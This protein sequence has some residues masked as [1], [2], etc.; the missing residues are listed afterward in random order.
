MLSVNLKFNLIHPRTVVIFQFHTRKFIEFI[1]RT[2]HFH[3]SLVALPNWHCRGKETVAWQI[4]I[5]RRFDILFETT[6]FQIFREPINFFVFRNQHGFRIRHI[7]EP[8]WKCSV[9]NTLFW[10]WIEWIFVFNIFNTINNP[11]FEKHLSNN[12]ICRPKFD[13]IFISFAYPEV[14]QPFLSCLH[15]VTLFIQKI[16]KIYFVCQSQIIVRLAISRSN[17]HNTC[18][19]FI[20]NIFCS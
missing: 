17:M 12:F 9:N 16:H 15:V 19:I 6:I 10:A 3:T 18:T 5:R 8:A 2:H 7:E 4:P 1:I 13:S 20:R 11:L 14:H